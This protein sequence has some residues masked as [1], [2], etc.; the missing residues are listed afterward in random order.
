MIALIL[1]KE[2]A[3]ALNAVLFKDIGDKFRLSTFLTEKQQKLFEQIVN[4]LDLKITNKV[5][6]HEDCTFIK[7]NFGSKFVSPQ[8]EKSGED[9][10]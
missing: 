3:D 5:L 4:E 10:S 8:D 1:T 6:S 2:K 9:P 7:F